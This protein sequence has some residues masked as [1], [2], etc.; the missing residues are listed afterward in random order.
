MNRIS[1]LICAMLVVKCSL[2]HAQKVR[3]TYDASGN[4]IERKLI[5]V[6]C[7]TE[8]AGMRR[9]APNDTAVVGHF[10]VAPNPVSEHLY[11][12]WQ[13]PGKTISVQRIDIFDMRG[14][15]LHSVRYDPNQRQDRI[16][17]MNFPPGIYILVALYSDGKKETIKVVKM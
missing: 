6:N 7:L 8:N 13:P 17:F 14:N 10:K 12:T 1:T 4:Q 5:C 2:T 3:F 11:V 16:P 15:K 9:E